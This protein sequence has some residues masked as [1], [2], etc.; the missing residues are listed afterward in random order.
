MAE[1]Q[2][3]VS[4]RIELTEG[5]HPMVVCRIGKDMTAAQHRRVLAEL[6]RQVDEVP[7]TR[8]GFARASRVRWYVPWRRLLVSFIPKRAKAWVLA[9][10]YPPPPPMGRSE[11]CRRMMSCWGRIGRLCN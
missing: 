2:L 10:M 9:K 1:D 4:L 6:H 7:S 5:L 11:R 3:I 8:P